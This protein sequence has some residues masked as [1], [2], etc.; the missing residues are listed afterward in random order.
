M[1]GVGFTYNVIECI[2]LATTHLSLGPLLPGYLLRVFMVE[3]PIVEVPDLHNEKSVATLFFNG[4]TPA[5][6]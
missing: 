1:V 4:H 6:T 5:A 3:H 2:G